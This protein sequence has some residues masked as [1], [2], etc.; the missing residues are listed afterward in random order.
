MHVVSL[1]RE[2][3]DP[4]VGALA[5]APERVRD[6]GERTPAPEIPDVIPNPELT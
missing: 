2:A 5:N 1:D 3:D 6:D 4:R